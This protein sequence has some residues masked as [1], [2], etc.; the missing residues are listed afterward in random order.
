MATAKRAAACG[1]AAL[2]LIG[3]ACLPV[4]A[5][6]ED[7]PG[8]STSEQALQ[9]ASETAPEPEEGEKAETE[10]MRSDEGIQG[11]TQVTVLQNDA[12]KAAVMEEEEQPLA[13]TGDETQANTLAAAL[14]AVAGSAALVG[15]AGGKREGGPTHENAHRS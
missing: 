12:S 13:D 9:T 2:A 7:P 5:W 11:G 10:S 15:A 4:T 8:S 1:L 3:R 6:A 14:A